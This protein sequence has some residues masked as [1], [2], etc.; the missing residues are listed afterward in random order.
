MQIC[1]RG[2]ALAFG[3]A[4][5]MAF[6]LWFFPASVNAQAR[7][8]IAVS[9]FVLILWVSQVLPHAIAGLG[10]CYLFWTLVRLPFSTAFGGF[11]QPTAWF[12][13]AAGMFG[14]MTTRTRLA[15]RLASG[16]MVILGSSYSRL[17]LSFVLTSLLLNFLVPSGIA[18]VIILAGI[19][20]GVVKSRGWGPQSVP[21]RGLFVALTVSSTL[22]DKLMITGGSTIVAQGIIENIAHIRVYWSQWFLAQLPALLLNIPLC[23]VIV[24]WLFPAQLLEPEGALHT[25]TD[26]DL[27]RSWSPAEK[28]CAFLL[29]AAL[30]I[31]M[32]DFI[33][34]VQPAMVALGIALLASL[35]RIGVLEVNE[36]K[37]ID[38]FPFLF[39]AS[40]LSLGDGLMRTGALDVVTR[41]LSS[42][43]QPWSQSFIPSSIVLYWTSFS[44]HLLVPSDPT[45][46]ATSLPTV[47][48]FA[49][50][51]QWSPLAA[52]LV[53]TLALSGKVFIYQSGVTIAAFSF[54]YFQARDYFKM[55]ICLAIAQFLVLLLLAGWYWPLIGLLR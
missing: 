3:L 19:G 13:F 6:V 40:A 18:R 52:G 47:I 49:L 16:L 32:T 14:L 36:L 37:Q 44:Y 24:L 46:L 42:L 11:A 51:H 29:A 20:L 15:H 34:H 39:T 26:G 30:L 22:F 48:H 1:S 35:P 7:H 21:A 2:K 10:G 50:T 8:A 38:F 45:T 28:R 5:S 4:L 33:H 55:G 43:W 12:V 17:I 27:E 53:W 23:W 54:G 9:L 41:A 31:W 25:G